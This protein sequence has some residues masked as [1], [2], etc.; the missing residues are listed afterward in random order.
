MSM[1]PMPPGNG[2]GPPPWQ[3]GPPPSPR[4]SDGF[5]V[6]DIFLTVVMVLGMVLLSLF[7]LLMIMLSPMATDRCH[8][9]CGSGVDV[10]WAAMWIG[11][12]VGA[13]VATGGVILAAVTR[14]VMF[15]WP[16]IGGVIIGVTT[17]IGIEFIENAAGM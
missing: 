15:I 11:L 8:P 12:P 7:A 10:A 3:G 6:A 17:W 2:S 9:D 13:L 5:L 4:R 1:Q 16:L 14:R